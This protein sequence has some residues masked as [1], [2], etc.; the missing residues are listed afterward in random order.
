MKKILKISLEV[1][2]VL[3]AVYVLAL[4]YDLNEKLLWLT[5]WMP[6]YVRN[7]VLALTWTALLGYCIYVPI[8]I[9]VRRI[10]IIAKS[11][12]EGVALK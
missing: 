6:D 4:T 5:S 9:I 12:K 3:F 11:R 10:G 8:P 7:W 1:L 2:A